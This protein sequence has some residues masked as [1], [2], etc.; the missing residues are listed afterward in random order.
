VHVLFAR[1]LALTSD[2]FLEL[3][4]NRIAV[5][6]SSPGYPHA[7]KQCP[8]HVASRRGDHYE[9]STTPEGNLPLFLACTTDYPSLDVVHFLQKLYPDVVYS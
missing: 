5:E 7:S 1:L 9:A 3:A 6:A 2:P 4:C 8:L